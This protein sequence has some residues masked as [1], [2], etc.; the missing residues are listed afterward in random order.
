MFPP[1]ADS[2]LDLRTRKREN[3]EGKKRMRKDYQFVLD[4][5]S[6]HENSV[7]ERN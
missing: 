5:S 4:I 1:E 3:V 2:P 6:A 7:Y